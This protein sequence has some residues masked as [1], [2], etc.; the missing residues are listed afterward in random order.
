MADKNT[1]AT[2]KLPLAKQLLAKSEDNK[3]EIVE[4]AKK[5]ILELAN[6]TADN[7]G[8]NITTE[9]NYIAETEIKDW[10]RKEEFKFMATS[11]GPVIEME[12][13]W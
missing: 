6:E 1:M 3:R 2:E 7:G 12:I 8:R 10:L 9:I 11:N 4:Q 5:E 13:W